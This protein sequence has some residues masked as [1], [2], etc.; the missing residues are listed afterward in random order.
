MIDHL[1]A[2]CLLSFGVKIGAGSSGNH[3]N[4]PSKGLI[5][6]VLLLW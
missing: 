3:V 6:E 2:I 5:G 4:D 1:I